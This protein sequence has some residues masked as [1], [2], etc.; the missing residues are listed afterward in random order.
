MSSAASV[1]DRLNSATSYQQLQAA[2]AEIV[3]QAHAKPEDPELAR[4]IDEVVRRLEQERARD[5]QELR[6]VQSRYESFQTQHQGV[7]GWFKRHI[8]FTETRRLEVEH[9]GEVADQQAE[10]LADN[11]VI[12]RAQMIKE[13]LLGPSQRKLGRRPPEWRSRYDAG[14][15][16]PN[17]TSLGDTLK[18]LDSEIERS[19]HF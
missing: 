11:L 17:L 4:T 9:R 13:R 10:I 14:L 19:G 3:S 1:L 18:E 12:A 2:F 6:E 16:P 7:V 15:S 8:P 5:E